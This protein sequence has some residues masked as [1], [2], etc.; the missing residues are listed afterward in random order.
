MTLKEICWLGLSPASS[1]SG[2]LLSRQV[3]DFLPERSI[4]CWRKTRNGSSSRNFTITDSVPALKLSGKPED[5]CLVFSYDPQ[6][7]PPTFGA[8]SSSSSSSSS[9]EARRERR[10]VSASSVLSD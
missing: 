7:R 6:P 4:Q 8:G 2:H 9:R 1:H 3:K 5:A 10:E